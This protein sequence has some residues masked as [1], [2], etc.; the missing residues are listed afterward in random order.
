MIR[1]IFTLIILAIIVIPMA[2]AA[3]ILAFLHLPRASVDFIYHTFFGLCLVLLGI[4]L[5][6]TVWH[7]DKTQL[8][9]QL[10]IVS[11]HESHLDIPSILIGLKLRSIRFVAKAS[12]F[13]IPFFGWG[14]SA[15]GNISVDRKGT[16]NDLQR[17]EES[18]SRSC[19]DILFF[20]EGTRSKDGL[21]QPFK[22]G[23]IVFA[24][25]QR[26]PIL[27]IAVGGSYELLPAGQNYARPGKVAVVV[28]EPIEVA[29]LT[30]DDRDALR[31]RVQSIVYTLR[32]EALKIAGSPRAKA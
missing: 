24:I 3:S 31:D 15:T 17:L 32:E 5:Q 23:G 9:E 28:G 7:T 10:V 14:M 30:I 4:K 13:R 18:G 2:T 27:P 29:Q 22:K 26:R 1:S 25:N 6:P 8:A 21:I 11:N 19:Y 12:L 16:G 20:A